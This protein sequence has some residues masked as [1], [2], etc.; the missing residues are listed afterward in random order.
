[1][2]EFSD[3]DV[4]FI[5]NYFDLILWELWSYEREKE[6]PCMKKLREIPLSCVYGFLVESEI[7]RE[8]FEE[9]LEEKDSVKYKI[10]K[11]LYQL[12]EQIREEWENAISKHEV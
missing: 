6:V 12:E 7:L 4:L 3:C 11:K 8:D 1:M 2:K 10:W 9:W 5:S